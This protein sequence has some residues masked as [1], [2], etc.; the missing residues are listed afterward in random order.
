[1]LDRRLSK[2]ISLPI[3]VW[4][5]S[6]AQAM[7]SQLS[8][9]GSPGRAPTSNDVRMAPE[10]SPGARAVLEDLCAVY[11]RMAA[12]RMSG[13]CT[14][15]SIFAGVEHRTVHDFTFGRSA[16]DRY[17]LEILKG[18]TRHAQGR[19]QPL[20]DGRVVLRD[21]HSVYLWRE[22]N[23][24]C[25]SRADN[26]DLRDCDD[27]LVRRALL[28]SPAFAPLIRPDEHAMPC[29]RADRIVK[30]PDSTIDGHP[31]TVL[32]ATRSGRSNVTTTLLVDL[33]THV[34]RRATVEVS[35]PDENAKIRYT[36]EARIEQS[37][38]VTSAT[39]PTTVTRR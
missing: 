21:G 30:L 5:G 19:P 2:L 28:E 24:T 8:A 18:S 20:R 31:C 26:E 17:R 32:E 38:T 3:L 39:T 14:Y 36:V 12:V 37:T 6:S 16:P 9:A 1:M 15:E 34:V 29:L 11:S 33:D 23:N 7:G 13:S 10:I 35:R 22:E 27:P 4:L 25:E